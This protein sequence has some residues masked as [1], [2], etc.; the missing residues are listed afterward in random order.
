[1]TE[2]TRTELEWKRAKDVAVFVRE[3]L[4]EEFPG[5]KFSV[6]TKTYSGGSSINVSWLD[7]PCQRDVDEKIKHLQSVSHMDITDLV[8]HHPYLEYKGERFRGGPSYIFATRRYTRDFLERVGNRVLELY[9]LDEEELPDILDGEYGARFLN[10]HDRYLEISSVIPSDDDDYQFKSLISRGGPYTLP[11]LIDRHAAR[12]DA[13]DLE[14]VTEDEEPMDPYFA[15][16]NNHV[17]DAG[18]RALAVLDEHFSEY[19]EEIRAAEEEGIMG[20]MQVDPTF[21]AVAYVALVTA[22]V[23]EEV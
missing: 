9:E 18:E 13:D 4:K 20:I 12:K 21:A 23:N 17:N 1:M 2:Q 15:L 14:E 5:T 7:G 22:F 11:Q 19:A 16:F 8:H 10:G 3:I 6:R